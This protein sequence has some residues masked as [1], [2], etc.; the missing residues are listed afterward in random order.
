MPARPVAVR[1][2]ASAVLKGFVFSCGGHATVPIS[3]GLGWLL[4]SGL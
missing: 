2:T 4:M 1:F 3:S